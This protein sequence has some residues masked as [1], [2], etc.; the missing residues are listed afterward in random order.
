MKKFYEVLSIEL[1]NCKDCCLRKSIDN[2]KFEEIIASH[3]KKRGF[4]D[5]VEIKNIQT[6]SEE[7]I[8]CF[9]IVGDRVFKN[10]NIEEIKNAIDEELDKVL[11]S[12]LKNATRDLSNQKYAK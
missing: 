12:V 4:E 11:Y 1:Y 2:N 6:S 3:V 5:F 10:I 9:V 7:Q 8:S